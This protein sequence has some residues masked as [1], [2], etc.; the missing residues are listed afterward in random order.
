MDSEFKTLFFKNLTDDQKFESKI[1]F[2]HFKKEDW[3]LLINTWKKTSSLLRYNNIKKNFN[4]LTK[5]Y[6]INITN[7]NSILLGLQYYVDKTN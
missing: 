1:L 7:Y 2:D 4:D 5:L 3:E 6:N